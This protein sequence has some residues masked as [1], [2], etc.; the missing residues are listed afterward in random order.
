MKKNQRK[1]KIRLIIF[2]IIIIIILLL[3]TRCATPRVGK[4][5]YD[6]S[7][8]EVDPPIIEIS[9]GSKKFDKQTKIDIF[10]NSEFNNKKIIAPGSNGSYD[11][12]IENKSDKKLKYDITFKD[13]MD[14]PVNM[15]YK[16]KIDGVYIHGNKD[17]YVSIEDLQTKD[18]SIMGN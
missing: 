18:L 17:N 6:D 9:D 8:L 10:S 14:N 3:I 1:Q 5:G 12:V 16:L 7:T 15:N 4:I 11:F 13:E 2:I